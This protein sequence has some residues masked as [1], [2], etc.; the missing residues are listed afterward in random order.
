MKESKLCFF[1]ERSSECGVSYF[2]L[3]EQTGWEPAVFQMLGR[4]DWS[5]VE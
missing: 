1:G 2:T 4:C 5:D 3:A